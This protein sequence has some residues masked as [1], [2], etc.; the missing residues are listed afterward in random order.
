M[1]CKHAAKTAAELHDAVV[2]NNITSSAAEKLFEHKMPV[3]LSC[4]S[5]AKEQNK[6]RWRSRKCTTVQ[7]A[8]KN[9]TCCC[10]RATYCC[11][12]HCHPKGMLTTCLLVFILQAP[13]KTP[14]HAGRGAKG[15]QPRPF[16]RA[17]AFARSNTACWVPCGAPAIAVCLLTSFLVEYCQAHVLGGEDQ[18]LGLGWVHLV[19]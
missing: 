14:Y 11:K 5:I 18:C 1:P 16:W 3:L 13:T 12:L 6:A 7:S 2:P 9:V 4:C 19:V 15:A 17:R 10:L 8:N